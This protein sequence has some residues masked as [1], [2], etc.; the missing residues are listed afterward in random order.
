MVQKIR[1]PQTLTDQTWDELNNY[2]LHPEFKRPNRES[3]M[4]KF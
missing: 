2:Y 1:K 3:D 4:H